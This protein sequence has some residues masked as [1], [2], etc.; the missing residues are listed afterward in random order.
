MSEV[1]IEN[2]AGSL[3]TISEL[4]LV[5]K[6]CQVTEKQLAGEMLIEGRAIVLEL[7]CKRL[8]VVLLAVQVF[9]VSAAVVGH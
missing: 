8:N 6:A 1:L 7:S 2:V 9:S 3:A 4:S 5:L